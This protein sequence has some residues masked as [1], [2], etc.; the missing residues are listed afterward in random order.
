MVNRANRGLGHPLCCCSAGRIAKA[1]Y[2][3][4]DDD[5]VCPHDRSHMPREAASSYAALPVWPGDGIC[6]RARST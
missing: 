4:G 3:G 1:I 2:I 6:R 5:A